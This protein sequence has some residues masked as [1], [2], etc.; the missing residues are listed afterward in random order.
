MGADTY[1]GRK[2]ETR[3]KSNGSSVRNGEFYETE[4]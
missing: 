4:R 3:M 2:E 1:V